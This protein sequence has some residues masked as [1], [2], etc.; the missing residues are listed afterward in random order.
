MFLIYTNRGKRNGQSELRQSGDK[1]KIEIFWHDS[2][3]K[4]VSIQSWAWKNTRFKPVTG[5]RHWCKKNLR[6]WRNKFALLCRWENFQKLKK[7]EKDL[8]YFK[9]CRILKINKTKYKSFKQFIL[10]SFNRWMTM[11]LRT[12]LSQ[13][14]FLDQQFNHFFLN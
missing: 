12:A 11:V 3:N 7:M 5:L 4:D 8:K 14:A 1:K 2:A 6:E 13:W 10:I 9:H